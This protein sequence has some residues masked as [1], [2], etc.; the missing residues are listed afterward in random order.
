MQIYVVYLTTILNQI[1]LFKGKAE[2]KFTTKLKVDG[3]VLLYKS[4][5]HDTKD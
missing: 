5:K 1:K 2:D 3:H 4:N